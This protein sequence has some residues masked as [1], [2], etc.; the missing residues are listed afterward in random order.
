M[1]RAALETSTDELIQTAT[2]LDEKGYVYLHLSFRATDIGEGIRIWKSTVLCDKNS[3]HES[4]LVHAFNIPFP[5]EWLFLEPGQI[6]QFLLIFEGLP[7]GCN[8][9]DMIERI[10]ESGGFELRGIHR[11]KS[12]VYRLRLQ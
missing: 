9:F 2:A 8:T 3:S 7:K 12:D 4:K 10:P 1:T 6:H 5:P 11:N